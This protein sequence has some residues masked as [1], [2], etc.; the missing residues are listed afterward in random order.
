LIP[1][2]INLASKAN[3]VDIP[4]DRKIHRDPTP[5]IGG[6]AMALA[7]LVPIILW[8]PVSDFVKAAIAGSLIVVFFGLLDDI[9]NIGFRLKFAGQ[10]IAALTVVLYGGLKLK[11]P[12]I[13][14]AESLIFSNWLSIPMTVFVIVAITNAINLS[15]GLDGLAGG[16]TLFTF[17]C[18]GYISYLNNQQTFE[19][20]SVAM[21]GSIFGLLR[22]NTHPAIVFM[23]DAGSQLLGFVAIILSIALT[24]QNSQLSPFLPLFIIGIPVIDTLSV[25]IQRI[26]KGKSPFIA[27]K[28]HLHHKLMS[29]GFYHSESVILIYIIHAILVCLAFVFRSEPDWLMLLLY[30]LCAGSILA[31][32]SLARTKGWSFKR[33]G[34]LDKIIKGKLQTL[35]EE[36]VIIKISFKATEIGFNFLIIFTC[37]LPK[38]INIYISISAMIFLVLILVAY[39]IKREWSY[40][41]TEVSIFLMIPFLAY[42]SETDVIYLKN[43][44]LIKAYSLSF[45][46]IIFSVLL[47]LKFTRRR[48][49]KTTPLDILI[50]LVAL[51]VPNLPDEGIKRWH[52]G[53]VAAKI[54]A[55][56]FTYEILKAELRLNMKRLGL[57]GF[58]ALLIISLRGF[59]G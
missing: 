18:I 54:I 57:A 27:D 1:I 43:T 15:D 2:L 20:I 22:Y 30:T 25:I 48:G 21:I 11:I 32:I 36:Q 53:F 5:R 59:I 26:A 13:F 55:L 6:V 44:V 3:I 46:I 35:K 19:V 42:L 28:N 14:V 24:Q 10:I 47:T 29:L 8:T 38:H 23:G 56:F 58:L 50:L 4:D 34:I 45:G 51:I 31:T 37:F 17:L 40:K 16:I 33:Y 41:I 7:A 9:K 49:F 12:E 39:I 52:M